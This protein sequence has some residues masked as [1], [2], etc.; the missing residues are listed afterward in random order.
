VNHER[1]TSELSL[2]AAV[3]ELTGWRQSM[4]RYVAGEASL[5]RQKDKRQSVS[6]KELGHLADKTLVLAI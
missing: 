1:L 3:H 2:L 5:E 6:D 4:H